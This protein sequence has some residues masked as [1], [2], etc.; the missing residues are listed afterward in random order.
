[1][2]C[3]VMLCYGLIITIFL[4]QWLYEPRST[5]SLFDVCC[6][7]VLMMEM[8][9]METYYLCRRYTLQNLLLHKVPHHGAF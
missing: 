9:P 8:K 1:M 7:L 4:N 3:Y 2:L 5:V 6:V